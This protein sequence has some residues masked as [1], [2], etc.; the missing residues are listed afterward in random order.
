MAELQ[1]SKKKISSLLSLSDDSNIDKLYVIPEYQ[2]P[3]RWGQIECDTLWTDIKSFFMY[4]KKSE[5]AP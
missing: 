5:D 3:Y 4:K 1:V 2:R